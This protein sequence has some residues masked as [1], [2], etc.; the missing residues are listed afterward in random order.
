MSHDGRYFGGGAW[1]RDGVVVVDTEDR[2]GVRAR[3]Q[4]RIPARRAASSTRSTITGPAAVAACWSSSTRPRSAS[5]NF[6][7]PTPYVSLYTAK[8]DKNGEVWAG[9]LQGGR[10]LRFTS[11]DRA[12]S[13]NMCCRSPTASTANP[14]ST[15]RPIRSPSGTSTTKA[16]WCASSRRSDRVRGAPPAR[17]IRVPPAPPYPARPMLRSTKHAPPA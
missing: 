3:H 11:E 16:I 12:R 8:A 7:L 9:E 17:G 1:P 10:Y 14:G 2:R 6:A 5:T 15:I 4:P 13:P